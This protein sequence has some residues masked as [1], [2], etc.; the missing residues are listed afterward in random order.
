MSP[1]MCK[2]KDLELADTVHLFDGPFGY[3]IVTKI[4]DDKV[5]I[6]RP[7]A[8]TADFSYSSGVIH[9]VGFEQVIL[10][11]YESREVRVVDKKKLR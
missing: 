11:K 5:H 8:A 9:F 1:L 3:G 4:E 10:F 6:F 2:A 7:Y